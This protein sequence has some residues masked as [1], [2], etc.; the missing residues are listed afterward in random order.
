MRARLC[1]RFGLGAHVV[2]ELRPDPFIL[3]VLEHLQV[4]GEGRQGRLELVG[5]VGDK[6]GLDALHVALLRDVAQDGERPVLE[7]GGP[8]LDDPVP[9]LRPGLCHGT[10]V[11]GLGEY[12][13]QAVVEGMVGGLEELP[14]AGVQEDRVQVSVHTDDRVRHT[15]EYG[16]PALLLLLYLLEGPFEGDGHSVERRAQRAYLVLDAR[17]YP[18]VEVACGQVLGGKPQPADAPGD[19]NRREVPC[20]PRR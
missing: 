16:A 2:Q 9:R 6:L 3:L 8:D 17:R 1:R 15:V 12:L 4:A 11:S 18:R 13:L 14:R 5:G 10:A 20:E 7:G 19:Q